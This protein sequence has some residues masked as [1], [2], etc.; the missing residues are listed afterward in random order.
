MFNFKI[1]QKYMK[2]KKNVEIELKKIKWWNKWDFHTTDH[3][4]YLDGE[5]IVCGYDIVKFDNDPHTIR[6]DGIFVNVNYQN[7]G[8]FNVMMDKIL[9]EYVCYIT[10]E[11]DFFE[12]I[13]IIVRK[14]SWI[15]EKYEKLGF[16]FHSNA[17]ENFDYYR[18]CKNNKK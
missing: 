15:I 3:H 4:L 6:I 18:L 17:D 8:I 16:E 9:N 14:N 11:D 10:G 5:K 7:N 2:I 1:M 12:N 13:E